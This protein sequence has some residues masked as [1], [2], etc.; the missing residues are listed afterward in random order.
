MSAK[1]DDK[2]SNVLISRTEKDTGGEESIKFIDVERADEDLVNV[3]H[4]RGYVYDNDMYTKKTTQMYY[5]CSLIATK[6]L[7]ITA[8]LTIFIISSYLLLGAL[9]GFFGYDDKNKSQSVKYVCCTPTSTRPPDISST[10]SNTPTNTTSHPLDT[11]STISNNGFSGQLSSPNFINGRDGITLTNNT[12][13]ATNTSSS[14]LNL[15][16]THDDTN[17]A[18]NFRI[19]I[20]ITDFIYFNISILIWKGVGKNSIYNPM[21]YSPAKCNNIYT[22]GQ[23]FFSRELLNNKEDQEYDEILKFIGENQN[24]S[25]YFN[26]TFNY[27]CL[28]LLNKNFGI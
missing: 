18:S 2:N 17:V 19:L 8:G 5:K 20:E 9:G 25:K 4:V 6:L 11:H 24:A 22:V 16:S 3:K 27:M 23:I 21:H 7:L 28:K 1:C 10:L 15:T 13:N 26:T 12:T 14:G